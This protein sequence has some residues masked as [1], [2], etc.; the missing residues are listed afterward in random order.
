MDADG[1]TAMY[2]NNHRLVLNSL[3]RRTHHLELAQ[4]LA[5]DTWLRAWVAVLR[6][7]E[8]R[9]PG[10]WL[11]TIAKRLWID[12]TRGSKYGRT[13]SL[14]GFWQDIDSHDHDW[15]IDPHDCIDA[16]DNR[17]DA[18]YVAPHFA[19]LPERQQQAVWLRYVEGHDQ[20]GLA[21]AMGCSAGA[22]KQAC[23]RGIATLRERIAA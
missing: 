22:A 5:G 15:L 17:L 12:H 16:A 11:T 23:T 13:S 6:G 1:F 2:E 14:D 18:R 21:A 4:D 20:Y 19:A 9:Y 3:F 7:E 10:Q 8:P